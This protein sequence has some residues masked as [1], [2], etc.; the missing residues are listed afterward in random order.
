MPH[1]VRAHVGPVRA[2]LY[3]RGT[4]RRAALRRTAASY[5]GVRTPWSART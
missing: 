4:P 1:L 3:G 5:C 2:G